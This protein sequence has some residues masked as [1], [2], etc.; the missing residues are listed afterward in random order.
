MGQQRSDDST[1]HKFLLLAVIGFFGLLSE[2]LGAGLVFA[3]WH[4]IP[5]SLVDYRLYVGA[6]LAFMGF[7]ILIRGM[8]W[9][10]KQIII[11]TIAEN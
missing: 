6:I 8:S 4:E 5:R 7:V 11:M 1:D 3:W 10:I 2:V 9:I